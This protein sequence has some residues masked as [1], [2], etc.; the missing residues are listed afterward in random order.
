MGFGIPR[1]EYRILGHMETIWI[2][3]LACV[4]YLVVSHILG[5]VNLKYILD[6]IQPLPKS[7][8][9]LI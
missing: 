9:L 1:M 4:T 8:V 6:L 5:K 2:S 3:M 7:A